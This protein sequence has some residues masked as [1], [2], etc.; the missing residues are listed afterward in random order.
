MIKTSG[1]WSALKFMG[2]GFVIGMSGMFAVLATGPGGMGADD[3]STG[4][5]IAAWAVYLVGFFGPMAI[6]MYRTRRK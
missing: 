2:L 1:K 6:W 4:R 5:F 3:V